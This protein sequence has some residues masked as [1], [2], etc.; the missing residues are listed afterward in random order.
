MKT[1]ME[2]YKHFGE[3]LFVEG[4]SW[5]LGITLSMGPRILYFAQTGREN[6]F[7]EQPEET[8]YLCSSEGWRVYGGTRLWLAPE[9]A[10][11]LYAPETAPVFYE[12]RGETLIVTQ[13]EDAS[14]HVVK[15]MEIA[16]TEEKNSVNIRYRITNTG[17]ETLVG[18]PWA[19][20]AMRAGGVLTAPF[21]GAAGEPVA[22]PERFLSLWNSTSLGDDRL[23]FTKTGV[24][25]AQ[26]KSDDYFKIGLFCA[27]G[28]AQYALEDQTFTK[29]FPVAMG[30]AY[31]DGG[32]NLEV[33]ACRQMLEF[34]TLAPLGVILPGE[35]AE[36]AERWTLSSTN[37]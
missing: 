3:C 6:V 15:Q 23:R 7:Y 4:E 12:W 5:K 1:R 35:T 28:T 2:V 20:S 21:A 10:H 18:A 9:G 24:E 30:A 32:V 31:P 11:A 16:P 34:E 27:A 33:F 19:V 8:D 36:H 26:K 37:K 13:A 14:L 29:T 25:I 17:G 22:K